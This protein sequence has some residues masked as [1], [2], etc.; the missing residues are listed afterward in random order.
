MGYFRPIGLVGFNVDM[1][2]HNVEYFDG[3]GF[4]KDG[5]KQIKMIGSIENYI[6]ELIEQNA[7]ELYNLTN[8]QDYSYVV[9]VTINPKENKIY[10]TPK[11]WELDY[12]TSKYEF[13]WKEDF[14]E[15]EIETI[16]NIFQSDSDISYI[17]VDWVAR[18]DYFQIQ[19]ITLD[20]GSRQR[21]LY[22]DDETRFKF[23]L[24]QIISQ[25]TKQDDW[26]DEEGSEGTLVFRSWDS[27]KLT[28][29]TYNKT[30]EMGEPI[31]IDD[32][33]FRK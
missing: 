24:K 12:E 32:E 3:I 23:F 26:M 18:Y 8:K 28:M 10:L 4:T 33:Y 31:V 29:N 25:V 1:D 27:G 21:A 19:E 7:K 30:F 5:G 9:D 17:I 14:R 13:N 22:M 16:Y 2:R 11:Y 20:T 6:K 15:T